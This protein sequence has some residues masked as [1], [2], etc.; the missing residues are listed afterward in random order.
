[1]A[2]DLGLG[3]VDHQKLLP[4]G[5]EGDAWQAAAGGPV[6]QARAVGPRSALRDIGACAIALNAGGRPQ[7]R[8]FWNQATMASNACVAA[9]AL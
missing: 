9:G 4:I 5:A 6:G 7:A 2:D 1:M 8:C 3:G